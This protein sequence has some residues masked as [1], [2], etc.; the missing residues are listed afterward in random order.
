MNWE[1][2]SDLEGVFDELKVRVVNP[3]TTRKSRFI[4]GDPENSAQ[5]GFNKTVMPFYS[6]LKIRKC[7]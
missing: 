3:F 2:K 1:L 5:Q 6:E 4:D 7:L